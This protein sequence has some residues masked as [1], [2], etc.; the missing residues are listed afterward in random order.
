M[1][2]GCDSTE[3]RGPRLEQRTCFPLFSVL[4]YVNTEVLCRYNYLTFFSLLLAQG[5]M[6]IQHSDSE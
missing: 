5:S 6:I 4:D 1:V 2:H 3:H